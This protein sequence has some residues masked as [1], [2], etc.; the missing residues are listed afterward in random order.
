MENVYRF[1][2]D[3]NINK[4]LNKCWENCYKDIEEYNTRKIEGD[5]YPIDFLSVIDQINELEQNIKN[6][7][8]M[9][10][11]DGNLWEYCQSALVV[12]VDYLC[13]KH[14]YNYKIDP[15]NK[16]NYEIVVYKKPQHLNI[17]IAIY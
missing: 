8:D 15:Y 1:N 7:K 5:M 17:I 6:K 10:I 9:F 11:L 16:D 14:E 13:K 4:I 3:E 2:N 12:I